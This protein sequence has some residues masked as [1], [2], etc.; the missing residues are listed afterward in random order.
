MADTS[1][2]NYW[3]SKKDSRFYET[4]TARYFTTTAQFSSSQTQIAY[5]FEEEKPIV[6]DE[7]KENKFIYV[8]TEKFNSKETSQFCTDV[9]LKIRQRRSP[10][11]NLRPII[12]HL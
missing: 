1:T 11:F 5:Y 10:A 4:L 12:F 7:K 3:K 9:S 8:N 6:E 2:T